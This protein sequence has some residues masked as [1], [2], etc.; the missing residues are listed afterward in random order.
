MTLS[1]PVLGNELRKSLLRR[2]PVLC[3]GGWAAVMTALTLVAVNLPAIN[4]GLYAQFPN[5]VLPLV[6]PAFAAG[7]F[8]K[9]HEQHTWQDLMLTRLTSRELLFGKFLAS[10]L[11]VVVVLLSISA[12]VLYGM[13]ANAISAPPYTFIT[14]YSSYTQYSTGI[15]HY[16]D[17][18]VIPAFCSLAL[19][20][21][22]QAAF[23]VSVAMVCSHYCSRA[24]QALVICYVSLGLYAMFSWF[25]ISSLLPV[26]MGFQI[27]NLSDLAISAGE[28][29][30][31]LT[32]AIL[33]IGSWV[34][35]SV[36]LKFRQG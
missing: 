5:I 17:T 14:P 16:S 25:L 15:Y 29:M 9:E 12:P 33:T 6:A 26:G 23:Y 31:L 22:L 21:L 1:N 8:A 13:T 27:L 34:L 32:C 18:Q 19:K 36:G 24:R 4:A 35:L 11:C 2:K 7:A 3:F 28:Q 30:H 20:C 10:Y